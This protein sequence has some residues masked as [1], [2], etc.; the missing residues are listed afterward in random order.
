MANEPVKLPMSIPAMDKP[1]AVQLPVV[2]KK[3]K[4]LKEKPAPKPPRFSAQWNA[5]TWSKR[6]AELTRTAVPEGWLNM[7]EIVKQA[8][9]KGIKVS[10]ICSAMGGDRC[11]DEPWDTLFQV[12]YVGGRKYGSPEILNRGFT[13]LLD[14][15]YHVTARIS[16]PKTDKVVVDAEGKVIKPK[17]VIQTDKSTVWTPGK[18]VE[19]AK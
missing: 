6:L 8:R 9:D 1:V 7:A 18:G 5:E 2:P 11:A 12:V 17:P 15:A 3:E 19:P 4:V 13:L 10:R 16:K 14:P